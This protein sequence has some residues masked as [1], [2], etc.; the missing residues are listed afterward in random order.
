MVEHGGMTR[1]T[2]RDRAAGRRAAAARRRQS[3]ATEAPPEL[4]DE[5]EAATLARDLA[6][7]V[8][9][10]AIDLDLRSDDE[11]SRARPARG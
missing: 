2:R 6:A 10:G 9:A 11:T 3:E 5:L 8:R 7:L 1:E 4:L